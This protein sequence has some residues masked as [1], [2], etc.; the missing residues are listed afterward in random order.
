MRSF[1]DGIVIFT[2]FTIRI[3]N[4]HDGTSFTQQVEIFLNKAGQ[5]STLKNECFVR[6]WLITI[7]RHLVCQYSQRVKLIFL[8]LPV[9][10][11]REEVEWFVFF[12]HHWKR[13]ISSESISVTLHTFCTIHETSYQKY[14]TLWVSLNSFLLIYSNYGII[15]VL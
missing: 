7:E 13:H 3:Y 15:T 14:L 9:A 12:A 11:S 8:E 5:F 6:W 1:D 2:I 4:C 10:C